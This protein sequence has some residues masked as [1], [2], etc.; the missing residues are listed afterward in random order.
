M[1]IDPEVIRAESHVAIARVIE[2]NAG[3]IIERWRRR[4]ATEQPN[5]RRVHEQA[6]LDHLPDLLQAIGQS[7]R[8]RDP[9]AEPYARPAR[10]HGGQRWDT[11]WSLTELVRDYQI[12]RL[13]LLEFIEESLDRP[14]SVRE[15]MAVGL[16]LDETVGTSVQTYVDHREAEIRDLERRRVDQ[17]RAL[18]ESYQQALLEQAEALKKNDRH[19]N[20][21]LALLGH[22]LRN[23]LGA[24]SNALELTRVLDPE[25][26]DF[27]Q[28]SEILVRQLHQMERLVDDLLDISRISRGVIEL[29]MQ[30]VELAT[31]MRDAD[32]V[33]RPLAE[34]RGHQL[35]LDLP[36]RPVLLDADPARLQQ[37]L[38]NLLINA[39]KYTPGSGHIW[40]SGEVVGGRAVIRV[41]DDGIGIPAE[42]LPDVFDLFMQA[43]P[44]IRHSEGGLGIGLTLVR[45]LV[46]LHGGTVTAASDGQGRGCQFEVSLPVSTRQP[47]AESPGGNDSTPVRSIRMRVLVVDDNLDVGRT[48]AAL[49][50]HAGHDVRLAH[51]GPAAIQIARDYQPET[52]LVD[53][54]LPGMDGY[55]LARRLRNEAGLERAMLAAL[56]GYGHE[57]DRRRSDEAG[58][59]HHLTKPVRSEML[60]SL[61]SGGR[62]KEPLVVSVEGGS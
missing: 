23:P 43:Q 16:A 33:A 10:Q 4:A 56:T 47:E 55:E 22:E 62:L 14:P 2:E 29:K 46:E 39:V 51:D 8:S 6:L 18:Q 57:E 59:D 20:E 26:P 11:G 5:A 41:K 15:W 60:L 54:G 31:A 12:L 52:V 42:M 61:L 3:V 24:M 32:S 27:R 17:E 25:D 7:L 13:V 44:A 45:K 35:H 28:A 50:K 34:A 30:P 1:S 9:G 21:F 37:V 19:K 48:L 49:L 40:L 53:I 36:A 58:F 38:M